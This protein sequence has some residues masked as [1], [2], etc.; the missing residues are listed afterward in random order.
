MNRTSEI[1]YKAF[2]LGAI[3]VMAAC[4]VVVGSGVWTTIKAL[5]GAL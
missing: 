5:A 2:C 1:A 3:F 4:V